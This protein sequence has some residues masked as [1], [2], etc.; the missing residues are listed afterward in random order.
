VL[1]ILSD[2]KQ[3]I[4]RPHGRA[5]IETDSGVLV[6]IKYTGIARPHGRARIETTSTCCTWCRIPASP[7]LTAGRGLKPEVAAD[8]IF[9]KWGGLARATGK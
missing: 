5:R 1:E 9:A 2:A 8:F 3:G 4:A 6:Q 7:G